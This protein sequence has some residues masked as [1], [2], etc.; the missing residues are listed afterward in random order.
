MGSGC[1]NGGC[2]VVVAARCQPR[3]PVAVRNAVKRVEGWQSWVE[4]AV[5]GFRKRY[6][7]ARICVG[8]RSGKA[9][10]VHNDAPERLDVPGEHARQGS[11]PLE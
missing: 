6:G 1:R 9:P 10:C 8:A 5:F 11:V 4:K 3:V 7:A 2:V